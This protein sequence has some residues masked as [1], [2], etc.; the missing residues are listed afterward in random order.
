MIIELCHQMFDVTLM[1]GLCEIVQVA[2]LGVG[3]LSVM[4]LHRHMDYGIHIPWFHFLSDFHT[5]DLETHPSS[6][7]QVATYL[8]SEYSMEHVLGLT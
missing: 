2:I 5:M 8:L 1:E 3:I 6:S 4:D 7:Q